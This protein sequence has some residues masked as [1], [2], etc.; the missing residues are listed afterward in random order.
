VGLQ[1][2]VATSAVD[3]ADTAASPPTVAPPCTVGIAAGV[4]GDGVAVA[5]GGDGAGA[6]AVVAVVDLR[7]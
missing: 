7:R 5:G 1:S 6:G 3:A 2:V 4:A